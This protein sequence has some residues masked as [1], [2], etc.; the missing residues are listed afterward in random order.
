MCALQGA[1]LAMSALA[2]ASATASASPAGA[3]MSGSTPL[4]SQSLFVTAWM[5]RRLATIGTRWLLTGLP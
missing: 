1:A 2:R 5:M 3:W 4:R